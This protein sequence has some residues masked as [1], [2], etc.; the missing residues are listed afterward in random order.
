MSEF[1]FEEF[2]FEIGIQKIFYNHLYY[3]VE[4]GKDHTVRWRVKEPERNSLLESGSL[5][6]P[7]VV[8]DPLDAVRWA[9]T[10]PR[11]WIDSYVKA[12]LS[13]QK[14]VETHASTFRSE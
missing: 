7:V 13:L 10:M 2:K 12:H 11:E 1:K 6:T 5:T 4:V 14:E 3:E 9:H 8:Q